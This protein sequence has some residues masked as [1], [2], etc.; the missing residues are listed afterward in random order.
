MKKTI[1]VAV[2]VFHASLLFAQQNELRVEMNESQWEFDGEQAELVTHRGTPAIRGLVGGGRMHLQDVEFSNG[3]IEFD[4][5]ANDPSFVG[6]F[7]RQSEDRRESEYFYLR[8]FW[9]VSPLL[10]T[11]TQ[12]S[13]VIDGVTMWDMTDEYQ[14]PAHLKQEGWNR[15]KLVVSGRQMVVYVNDMEKPTMHVPIME[16]STRSGSIS[17]VGMATFANL[18]IKPGAT[19]GLDPTPGYDFTANDSRYLRDW[20]VSE[21]MSFPVEQALTVEIIPDSTT[22]WKPLKAEHRALVNLTRAFGQT[23]QGERRLVWLKTT[24]TS[25]TVQQRRMS[26]GFSDEVWILIRGQFLMM[27]KNYYGSPGMKEPRGRATIENTSVMLPLQEGENEIMIGVANN[28]FG[29]GIFARLDD[30]AGLTA[31]TP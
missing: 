23:P 18:V 5:E 21:P 25:E 8:T 27:D 15:V 6:I 30:T 12:Y 13:T 9:P 7:F 3:T 31:L 20:L 29:W 4:V 19:E 17:L 24:I 10:R 28:F 11:A 1:A 26:L 16:G 2:L 22:T 14:A